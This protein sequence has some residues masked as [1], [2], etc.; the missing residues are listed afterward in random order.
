M[1]NLVEMM[2]SRE[3]LEAQLAIIENQKSL[4]IKQRKLIEENITSKIRELVSSNKDGEDTQMFSI[5][6]KLIEIH[7]FDRQLHH[8]SFPKVIYL[9]ENL[10]TLNPAR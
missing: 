4:I 7:C 9:D 10:K 8:I 6:G 3:Q 2:E 5:G 1:K